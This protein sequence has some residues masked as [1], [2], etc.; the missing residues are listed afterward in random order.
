MKRMRKWK[1]AITVLLSVA[2]L[3][4]AVPQTG[5]VALAAGENEI[6][7]DAGM[8]AVVQDDLE[9]DKDGNTDNGDTTVSSGEE[10]SS[11]GD[12]S[13][14]S[15]G[16]D[17]AGEGS[18]DQ[19]VTDS[20]N[21][22]D[23]E[24]PENPDGE[25]NNEEGATEDGESEDSDEDGEGVD[26][27]G[28]IEEQTEE[29]SVSM[30]TLTAEPAAA[31]VMAD[32]PEY[33][34]ET[35]EDNGY[36]ELVINI[37][38][39]ISKN[40]PGSV[41]DG[42]VDIL[43]YYE[44]LK[45]EF[46]C[47]DI[48]N[49]DQSEELLSNDGTVIISQKIVNAAINVW[50]GE[51]GGVSFRG[52]DTAK[53]MDFW[54]DF[55]WLKTM[56]EDVEIKAETTLVSHQG[57]KIN[58]TVNTTDFP[59]QYTQFRWSKD[60]EGF[61]DCFGSDKECDLVL[62]RLK[63]GQPAEIVRDTNGSYA[64]YTV[65]EEDAGRDVIVNIDDP[66]AL[67]SGAE[68]LITPLYDDASIYEETAVQVGG[69]RQLKAGYRTG[70]NEVSDAKWT[71]WNPEVVTIDGNGLLSAV[72]V[73][74]A[75]YCETYTY[76][77]DQC[78]ELHK[79]KTAVTSSGGTTLE[80]IGEVTEEGGEYS[81]DI[82]T[83]LK[84]KW[85]WMSN[86]E[87]EAILNYY[88]EQGEKFDHI[89]I[90]N[91]YAADGQ[92]AWIPR[93]VVNAA[94]KVLK[95]DGTLTYGFEIT[96]ATLSFT[97]TSPEEFS[98]D[99]KFNYSERLI[100]NQGLKIKFAD[101]NINIPAEFVTCDILWNPEHS[102]KLKYEIADWDDDSDPHQANYGMF[103]L[104]SG[105]PSAWIRYEADK[106]MGEE[107]D[108]SI[109]FMVGGLNDIQL[110]AEYL[111]MPIYYFPLDEE[112]RYSDIPMGKQIQLTA[113]ERC[114]KEIASATWKSLSPEEVTIDKN[115]LL[116]AWDKEDCAMY[117]AKYNA[118]GKAY[119]EMYVSSVVKPPVQIAFDEDNIKL[120]E[121]DEKYL[122]LRF[123]PSDA[124]CDP[125]NPDEITWK[126]SAPDV[127]S[128]LKYNTSG[129][130]DE[131]GNPNGTIKAV[132]EGTA[133]ITAYYMVNQEDQNGNVVTDGEGNPI[134]VKGEAVAECT[135]TVTKP[136]TYEDVKDQI[137][138]MNLYA[139]TNLDTKLSDIALPAGW[140]WKYPD[141]ALANFKDMD[142]HT[143]AAVY[144]D[145]SDRTM[146]W[147][148]W[149]RMV[150]VTGVTISYKNEEA[151]ESEPEWSEDVPASMVAGDSITLGYGYIVEN[152]AGE[153][154]EEY[155]AVRER[156]DER[157][158]IEWTSNPKNLGTVDVENNEYKYDAPVTGK[159]AE[160]K[161]F[162]VS[163][164]DKKTNKVLF[165]ASRTI[166][167]TVK[168][169]YDFD[170]IDDVDVFT[171]RDGQMWLQIQVDMAKEE[172]LQQPLTVASEDT[173]ILK[174]DTKKKMVC[175]WDDDEETHEGPKTLVLIPCTN[176]KPGIA[177]IKVTAPDEMKSVQ[178]YS[179]EFI[180]KEPKLIDTTAVSINRAMEDKTATVT[181]RTRKDCPLASD[182]DISL[183]L[184]K[185]DTAS[186]EA[187]IVDRAEEDAEHCDYTI[188]LSLTE[189]A[190][191]DRNLKKGKNT[192]A[193]MLTVNPED[194]EPE[195]YTLNLTLN[196]T[197][198]V[199]KVS[200]KQTKNVNLFYNDEEGYGVLNVDANGAVIQNLTLID[201][202]DGKNP[203]KDAQC[204]FELVEDHGIYYI[205]LKDSG[206]A[207]NKKGLLTY[208]LEG[209]PGYYWTTFTVKTETKKPV[210]VLSAKSEILYPNAGYTDSWLTMFDKATGECIELDVNDEAQYVANKKKGLCTALNV[211]NFDLENPE[212]EVRITANNAYNLLVTPDGNIVSRLQSI[213]NQSYSKKADKFNLE[214]KKDNWTDW[215]AV[216]YSL[217]VNTANPKLVLG[218]STL[219]LNKNSEVYKAQMARTSLRLKGYVDYVMQDE[220]S[221]V[222]ITGQD[223]KSKK[224]LKV[225]NSLVVQYWGDCGDI[226]VKF[227]NNK[228]EKG[229]YKFN[230]SV[231]N[232]DAGTIAST[233]LTVEV[234][235]TAMDKNLKVSAKG[236][237]DVLDREG[238]SIAYT[239]KLSNLSGEIVDGWLEGKDSALFRAEF[240]NGRL[241]VHAEGNDTDLSTKNTYQV[242]AVFLVETQDYDCYEVRTTKP[243]SIKVKQGKPKLT[244]STSSNTLYRQLDNTV[245]IRLDAVLNKK[246]VEIEDVWLL[247]YTEDLQL[248]SK[249]LT[250]EEGHDY[251]G[252]YDPRT[253]S[254]TLALSDRYYADT[255]LQSGKTW[256]VKLAVRYRDKAG[257]EKNAE[258]TCPVVVR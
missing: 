32:A 172:Y 195:Q 92:Y 171:D 185:R 80:Y 103:K 20:N 113:G 62:M 200:F 101:S 190:T 123:Y 81:L 183:K 24:S 166:T 250:D 213:E 34:G 51:Y 105:L 40:A 143:F 28:T 203:K 229:K 70:Y 18:E 89:S 12:K 102:A 98:S 38:E 254:V 168:P 169:T 22:D 194:A 6:L 87:I 158:S 133:T 129:A 170:R 85:R 116:T 230:I 14:E 227:N 181:V 189:Q 249:Q 219:K 220:W 253:K 177:W 104:S 95:D 178:R 186:I 188:K 251:E 246:E 173:A 9:Q 109:R 162:T 115:G 59:G 132:G 7:E 208:E 160:K 90:S 150:T 64:E 163:V 61:Y 199:P 165:K 179:I 88:K 258:V 112:G 26:E 121:N 10:N 149:V 114:G 67:E 256:K 74:E 207:K 218:A 231:G 223:E 255:I 107:A 11:T 155:E 206:N 221:W 214:I 56:N 21:G 180:D 47:I 100:E 52:Y 44:D 15:D 33:V 49:I 197:D 94:R 91:M 153:T 126:S 60:G 239:P 68:Y 148:L 135:V 245:E 71:S 224:A 196:V 83:Y 97:L 226:I 4:T 99:V 130:E 78:L 233:T 118:D 125:G 202:T 2:M 159:K 248:V 147:N 252:I 106:L 211:A 145:P 65:D 63:D 46:R 86:N 247:N 50:E 131:F 48:Y 217:T 75:Y 128:L 209:Y 198:S 151:Q 117:Y 212:K 43:E 152:L 37:S 84:S 240:D 35:Y 124:E 241:F 210:I 66:S 31:E 42:V 156:M 139:V 174:L 244:A 5:A 134:R 187:E 140:T 122:R 53:D 41:I 243:L 55:C 54:Y 164:K 96:N 193:M 235:D 82:N 237:I 215:V 216:S 108:G 76:N 225:D 45:K 57:M 39:V 69:T 120:N 222:S 19:D 72:S 3:V 191:A 16:E 79:V 234:I 137:D 184:N 154:E 27:E 141:T 111:I 205:A 8:P 127:V 110:N 29:E 77:D 257:N 167:V 138:S 73:G 30:N 242:D 232:E 236:A 142:G 228:I 192:V 17:E 144:T 175:G 58:L 204:D 161:T 238:T 23:E 201:Y 136:L 25:E 13:E 93:Q 146:T 1:Q 119:L 36:P 157:Y 176:P 182:A